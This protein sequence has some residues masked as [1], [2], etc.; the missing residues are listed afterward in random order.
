MV[1]LELFP[2]NYA[3]FVRFPFFNALLASLSVPVVNGNSFGFIEGT[4]RILG[5][6]VATMFQGEG[7]KFVPDDSVP[8]RRGSRVLLAV[9]YKLNDRI[10]GPVL[11]GNAFEEVI[12]K[13][14]EQQPF[15]LL[16]DIVTV[17]MAK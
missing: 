1:R 2:G 13:L 12:D 17:K 16:K 7:K 6:D 10:A 11:S 4:A 8:F 5:D 14:S 9:F 15:F 3:L